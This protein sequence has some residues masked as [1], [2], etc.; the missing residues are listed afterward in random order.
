MMLSSP[1]PRSLGR[2]PHFIAHYVCVVGRPSNSVVTPKILLRHLMLI[3][4][5]CWTA[6]T[7][8]AIIIGPTKTLGLAT[9]PRTQLEGKYRIAPETNISGLY[10]KLRSPLS[11]SPLTIPTQ[12]TLSTKWLEVGV[13]AVFNEERKGHIS[14]PLSPNNGNE[15]IIN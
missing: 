12:D 6:Q 13:L 15:L 10:L 8:I 3:M 9:H 11:P 2:F 4:I 7:V 14:G 5:I 1:P